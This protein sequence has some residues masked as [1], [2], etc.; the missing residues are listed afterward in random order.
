M[1]PS[2]RFRI[3]GL[4]IDAVRPLFG[5]ADEELAARGIRRIVV[6][7][8]PGFPDRIELRDADIGET[9]LLLNHFHQ[10]AATPYR[11]CH[12]IFVR[13]AARETWDRF[14]EVPDVMRRRLLSVRGFDRDH[15]IVVADVT[16]GS[17]L[18]AV[19]A[20]F[21]ADPKVAYLHV[22]YAKYGCWAGQVDRT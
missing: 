21:F 19:I 7:A 13:E 9:V 11:S 10:P 15:M 5:L 12:A 6:D 4:D 8:S 22:H 17:D 18:E 2:P 16:E 20:R 3:R 14:D 1:N